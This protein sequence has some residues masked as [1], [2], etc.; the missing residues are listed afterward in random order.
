MKKFLREEW[1][2]IVVIFIMFAPIWIMVID[3]LYK[4]ISHPSEISENPFLFILLIFLPIIAVYGLW[5]GI[6]SQM[7]LEN[8]LAKGKTITSEVSEITKAMYDIPHKVHEKG[9]E[10]EN[11]CTCKKE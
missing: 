5:R 10:K 7:E 9:Y 3:A 2:F 1:A 4:M 6:K 8:R 11:T